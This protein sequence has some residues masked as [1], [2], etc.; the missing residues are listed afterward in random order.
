MR[1]CHAAR[2][3]RSSR[4]RI[5]SWPLRSKTPRSSLGSPARK[6]RVIKAYQANNP[7]RQ[8]HGGR[9]QRRPCPASRRRPTSPSIR[10]SISPRKLTN[11]ILLEKNLL[12]LGEGVLEGTQNLRQHSSSTSACG[13]SSNF[14]NMFWQCWETNASCRSC[15]CCRSR[16]LPTISYTISRKCQSPLTMWTRANPRS[17]GPEAM[18]QIARFILFVGPCSSVLIDVF[19]DAGFHL[20]WCGGGTCIARIAP[21]NIM[22]KFKAL[23]MTADSAY[24]M[25]LFQT[26][27]FVQR[28][29]VDADAD[30]CIHI[31][32]TIAF[33][34]RF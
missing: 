13:A 21:L 18:N 5:R 19:H 14:G 8:L 9:H 25:C 24:R 32:R 28:I 29:A 10:R 6:Q 22:E 7:H 2:Q 20:C 17:R 4:C 30:L 12:V 16:F 26:G 11:I 31:I 15:R 33:R 1:S 27:W 3:S 34:S 23:G